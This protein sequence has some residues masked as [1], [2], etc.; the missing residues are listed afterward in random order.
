MLLL[1]IST[2]HR[3]NKI[4]YLLH[5]D[6]C[7]WLQFEHITIAVMKMASTRSLIET[8]EANF[9]SIIF[10]FFNVSVDVGVTFDVGVDD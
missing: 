1:T 5:F 3:G 4:K 8:E 6:I 10:S 9:A 2:D 7:I